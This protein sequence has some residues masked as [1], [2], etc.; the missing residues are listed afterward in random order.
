[1]TP[2][3]GPGPDAAGPGPDGAQ[4]SG[5]GFAEYLRRALHAVA[6][7]IEPQADGLAPIRAGILAAAGVPWHQAFA[8][9]QYWIH[10]A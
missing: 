8:I 7:Q 10:D 2:D 4:A 3:A 9:S 1:M 5:H 6:D